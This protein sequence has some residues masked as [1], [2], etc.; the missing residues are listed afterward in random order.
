MFHQNKLSTKT[1]SNQDSGH[2]QLNRHLHHSCSSVDIVHK[3]LKYRFGSRGGGQPQKK[4]FQNLKYLNMQNQALESPLEPGTA[5]KAL[6]PT[7]FTPECPEP[8]LLSTATSE[9]MSSAKFPLLHS[10]E[11][12]RPAEF[13]GSKEALLLTTFSST[14]DPGLTSSGISI[15]SSPPS[16]IPVS[17]P[18]V[19][20]FPLS[21]LSLKL[22]LAKALT[23]SDSSPSTLA[24][25]DVGATTFNS[26]LSSSFTSLSKKSS[27]V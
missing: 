18:S 3:N 9:V 19:S 26:S 11:L 2:P 15:P 27:S 12:L 10:P 16:P 8:L 14:D 24:S 7:S 13:S 1:K 23:S 4:P 17:Q 22:R 5:L 20:L 6:H 25:P 21:L